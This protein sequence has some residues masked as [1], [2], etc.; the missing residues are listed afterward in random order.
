M[1]TDAYATLVHVRKRASDRDSTSI[2]IFGSDNLRLEDLELVN[3]CEHENDAFNIRR[4]Y[5]LFHFLL[6]E[7]KWEHQRVKPLVDVRALAEKTRG[8]LLALLAQHAQAGVLSEADER[9]ESLR[10]GTNAVLY[11]RSILLNFDYDQVAEIL[12]DNDCVAESLNPEKKTYRQLFEN[13]PGPDWF[14]FLKALESEP[15]EFVI[16]QYD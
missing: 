14:D 13:M 7:G 15:Y 8:F 5:Y 6:G 12:D 16:F 4:N 1:G 2:A 9:V 10:C 11:P 3:G